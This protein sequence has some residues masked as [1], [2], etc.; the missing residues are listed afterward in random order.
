MHWACAAGAE[1]SIYYL[2]AY[3]KALNQ[4]DAQG[5]T[6]LHTAVEKIHKFDS[7]RPFKEMLLI[8][9]DREARDN[10][11]LRPYNMLNPE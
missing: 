4:K 7:A 2:L 3:S 11:G 8:G 5:R 1:K 9:A 10:K 6:P